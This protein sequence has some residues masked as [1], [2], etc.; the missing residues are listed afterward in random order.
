MASAELNFNSILELSRFMT[1]LRYLGASDLKQDEIWFLAHSSGCGS[2]EEEDPKEGDEKIKVMYVSFQ[3]FLRSLRK[4][5]PEVNEVFHE[6]SKFLHD[7]ENKEVFNDMDSECSEEIDE[8]VLAAQRREEE[9]IRQEALL[10]K[11]TEF[12][13]LETDSFDGVEGGYDEPTVIHE[14]SEKDDLDM[15]E[16]IN[17][18]DE[19]EKAV[20]GTITLQD[21]WADGKFDININRCCNCFQHYM[22]SWHAEDEYVNYFNDMGEAIL[23]LFPNANLKGN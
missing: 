1:A 9:K 17:E 22:Y 5:I 6:R 14:E 19:E 18:D 23:G 16:E 8:E 3:L 12:E 7:Q 11:C 4:S 13:K 20:V 21:N 2:I 10:L 15:G